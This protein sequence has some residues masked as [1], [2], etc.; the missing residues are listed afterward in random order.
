MLSNH[1]SLASELTLDNS[2]LSFPVV[3]D[4]TDRMPI[5]SGDVL[6]ATK[7]KIVKKYPF[8]S[9]AERD[10]KELSGSSYSNSFGHE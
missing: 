8:G 4:L 5:H 3:S 10:S 7:C 9:T 2:S 1:K 6:A